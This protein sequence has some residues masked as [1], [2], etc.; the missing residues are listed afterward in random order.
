[1][2]TEGTTNHRFRIAESA[3]ASTAMTGVSLLRRPNGCRNSTTEFHAQRL[4]QYSTH[5]TQMPFEIPMLKG[6]GRCL[7]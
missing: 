4:K 3:C 2:I 1:M 7:T 6:V 5:R